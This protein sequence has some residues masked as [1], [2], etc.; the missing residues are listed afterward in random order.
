MCVRV[1]CSVCH[2][3]IKFTRA[4]RRA[5][6]EKLVEVQCEKGAQGEEQG[7]VPELPAG[8]QC[9]GAGTAC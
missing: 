7:V 3:G 4:M 9:P 1:Y 6:A 8:S 2:S 5:Q